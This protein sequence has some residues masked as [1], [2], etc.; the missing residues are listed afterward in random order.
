MKYKSITV[1]KGWKPTKIKGNGIIPL[2]W[3]NQKV[4]IVSTPDKISGTIRLLANCFYLEYTNS[5]WFGKD[6]PIFQD[7]NFLFFRHII[8]QDNHEFWICC[9]Y[10]EL[11]KT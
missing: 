9:N 6:N 7:G 2:D 3:N 8:S 1:P 5:D 11:T 10:M 4:T